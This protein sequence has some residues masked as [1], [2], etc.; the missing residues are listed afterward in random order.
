MRDGGFDAYRFSTSWARVMPEGEAVN[1]EGLD[2]YDRLVDA[3][4]ARGLK[5]FLTLY[6]WDMP[7]ALSDLGGWRN[8][9][10]AGWFADYAE[11]VMRPHRRPDPC[12][13]H[14]QRALVRRPG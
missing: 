14:D 1:P 2:F 7:A 5:P 10:V 11:V 3:M 6:H 12:H 9:D 13:R 4:L 8:R